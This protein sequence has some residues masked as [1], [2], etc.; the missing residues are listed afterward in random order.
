METPFVI[1]RCKTHCFHYIRW[2][3]QRCEKLADIMEAWP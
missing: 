3:S 2:F 1:Q